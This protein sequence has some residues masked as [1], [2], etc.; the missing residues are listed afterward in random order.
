[1]NICLI[2]LNASL[3][4]YAEVNLSYL[5]RTFPREKIWLISDSDLNLEIAKKFGLRVWKCTNPLSSWEALRNSGLELN[6]RGGFYS[7]SL[8]RFSALN[9]FMKSQVNESVLHVE[10]DV[11]LA[12][13][14]PFREIEII[15]EDIAFPL[16]KKGVVIPSTIFIKNSESMLRL[17]GYLTDA[18]SKG[19]TPIDMFLLS[20]YENTF[21]ERV[22]ILPSVFPENLGFNASVDVETKNKILLNHRNYEGIFDSST[23]GQFLFGIDPKNY[24]GI[25]MI[26]RV[27]EKH[28]AKI[29]GIGFQITSEGNIALIRGS[30]RIFLYSLH[31]HSKDVR[32]FL[33]DEHRFF[34]DRIQGNSYR[35][36]YEF[37]PTIFLNYFSLRLFVHLLN[38][39][40]TRVRKKATIY[41]NYLRF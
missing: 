23:W 19:F 32:V 33:K 39:V 37:I 31:I 12:P 5:K 27:Q 35:T 29:K 6:Y 36:K 16:E 7:Y 3:P 15:K 40:W 34:R 11:W 8:G 25:R 4:K 10:T 22:H 21:P 38:I 41:W 30:T 18:L 20:L 1:M 26:Y 28:A 14:F 2:Y 17:F 13:N 24:L 9:E